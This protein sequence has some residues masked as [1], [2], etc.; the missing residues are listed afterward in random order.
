M[1]KKPK[2]GKCVH[3]LAN[4][5]ERS[6]DHVFPRSWY[7]E[8]TKSDI[9]KWQVPSCI[10]CN[11]KLGKI[12]EEF[13]RQ[14]ALCLDPDNEATSNIVRKAL[15]SMRA[16]E[17]KN[18]RDQNIRNALRQKTLKRILEGGDIP[19]KG[20]YP[21]LGEKWGR[22]REDQVAVL[23]PAESFDRINEKI[24]RG[25]LYI[26]KEV[27]IAPPY[28]IERYALENSDALS[29]R[30]MLDKFGKVYAR[31]PGIVIRFAITAEDGISSFFEIELWQQFKMYAS[32]TRKA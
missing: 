27:F 20:T 4:P 17:A 6:W 25:I 9:L 5:V 7:P 30:E 15:R 32:V 19:S 26:E 23:I 18:T 3:C 24:V 21:G 10:P 2:T 14:V 8:T 12:E 31:Q 16:T 1:A 28:I 22:K 11:N 13:L 29:I